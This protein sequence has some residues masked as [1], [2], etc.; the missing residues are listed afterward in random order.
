MCERECAWVLAG[1]GQKDLVTAREHALQG[2]VCARDGMKK[3]LIAFSHRQTSTA[4]HA[5]NHTARLL[6]RR[7]RR[8]SAKQHWDAS[9]ATKA[10]G[11]KAPHARTTPQ[12]RTPQTPHRK[13]L[14]NQGVGATS[15]SG[16]QLLHLHMYTHICMNVC[17]Y[18]QRMSICTVYDMC[19]QR[20]ALA[21]CALAP[22][23]YSPG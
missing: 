20:G 16:Q 10:V 14:C 3:A 22:I 5:S 4:L 6:V 11:L 9:A 23:S 13:H 8:A 15:A 1:T 17:R 21:L 18:V 7:N 12:A 19:L 2:Q